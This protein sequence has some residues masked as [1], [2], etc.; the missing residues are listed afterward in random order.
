MK[1]EWE[2]REKAGKSNLLPLTLKSMSMLSVESV[3]DPC[4]IK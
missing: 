2:R 4:S 3:I 1:K